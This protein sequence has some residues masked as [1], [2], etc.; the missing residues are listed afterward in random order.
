M[1]VISRPTRFHPSDKGAKLMD[2]RFVP[3]ILLAGLGAMLMI[4]SLA[5]D[6]QEGPPPA[7]VEVAEAETLS[8]AA[9]VMAPGTI[10]SR[11]DAAVAAEVPGSLRAVAEVGD[12]VAAGDVIAAIDD[13]DT[14]TSVKMPKYRFASAATHMTTSNSRGASR[15]ATPS[16]GARK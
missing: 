3:Q 14:G 9:T 11:N 5:A 4:W 12:R 16:A 1:N 7:P 13:S 10:V 6:A 8:M 2:T 15:P